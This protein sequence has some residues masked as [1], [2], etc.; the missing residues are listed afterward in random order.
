MRTDIS[1]KPLRI[2]RP[3]AAS[4][5]ISCMGGQGRRGDERCPAGMSD[6]TYIVIIQWGNG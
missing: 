4:H 2:A 5:D 3:T 1:Q 6:V